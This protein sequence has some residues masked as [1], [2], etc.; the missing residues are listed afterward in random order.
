MTTRY[1][2]I[3]VDPDEARQSQYLALRHVSREVDPSAP[4]T[5]RLVEGLF[6]CLE[7]GPI[8]GVGLSA[9]QVG[10]L[11]RI[12]VVNIREQRKRTYRAPGEVDP[13]DSTEQTPS[14]FSPIRMAV[15]NPVL[16]ELSVD[17]EN[18]YEG[19]LSIPG[20]R[21]P[22]PRH[23]RLRVQGYDENGSQIDMI[24]EDFVARVF[25]HEIDHLDG[26]LYVD[27]MEPDDIIEIAPMPVP[28]P[29]PEP[30]NLDQEKSA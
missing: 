18:D 12:F 11:A 24:V 27:R 3:T 15:I 17:K 9:P 22:V 25:Q 16:T 26:I 10:I 21:G 20:Y 13:S 7:E 1:S 8:R 5:K 29:P 19:C 2:I 14:D 4:E 30:E 23:K 28:L 6:E